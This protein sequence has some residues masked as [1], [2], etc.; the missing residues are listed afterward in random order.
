MEVGE[1]CRF[2]FH[3][4]PSSRLTWKAKYEKGNNKTL[5]WQ[6]YSELQPCSQGYSV[7]KTENRESRG[8]V[9]KKSYSIDHLAES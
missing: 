3:I 5:E 8:G 4:V 6:L 7:G 1:E 2:L 9:G